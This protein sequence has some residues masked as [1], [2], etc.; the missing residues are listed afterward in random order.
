M[1]ANRLGHLGI[2]PLR[3]NQG[4]QLASKRFCLPLSTL[5]LLLLLRG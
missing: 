5:A 1:P 4:Q 3:I 2:T